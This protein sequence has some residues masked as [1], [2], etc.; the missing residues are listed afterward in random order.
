MCGFTFQAW[1]GHLCSVGVI[2]RQVH[3]VK[4]EAPEDLRRSWCIR[5]RDVTGMLDIQEQGPLLGMRN[6]LTSLHNVYEHE[7][8]FR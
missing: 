5:V 1:D 3:L 6:Y 7:A 4:F 2:F 8:R